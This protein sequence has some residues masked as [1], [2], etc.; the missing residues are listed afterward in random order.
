MKL[1]YQTFWMLLWLWTCAVPVK[2][3]I[4]ITRLS[5]DCVR[6]W[7]GRFRAH[8]PEATHIL[9][10]IVQLDEAFFKNMTLGIPSQLAQATVISSNRIRAN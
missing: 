10:R 3:A 1:S 4:T 5:D 9:E 6:R 8:L 7:Y 2:Q